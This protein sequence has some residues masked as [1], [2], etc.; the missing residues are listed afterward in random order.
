MMFPIVMLVLN[1]TSVAVL[2]FGAQRSRCGRHADR[3]ADRLPHLPDPDPDVGD[4]GHLLADAAAPRRSVC[5]E[6]IERGAGH[7]LV[8]GA[9]RRTRSSSCRT[10]SVVELADAEFTYPG[11]ESPVLRDITFTARAGP[12]DRDHRLD[13]CRQDHPGLADPA[14]VRRD[15]RSGPGRRGRRPRARSRAALEPDRPGAAEAVPVLRHGGV[16]NLRYGNPDATDEELW[17][18]LRI[19]QAEDFVRAMPGSWTPRS[20][21]A[22]PTSPA[23][24]GNGCPS[25]G[26]W[27]SGRRSTCSTTRSPPWTWP[28]MPGCEPRCE[29]RPPAPRDH[30]RRSGWRPSP[31]PTRSWCWR[32]AQ[33][34]GSGTH[35]E[36]LDTCPTYAEIV[37]SQL[38]AE[39]A[40][41]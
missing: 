3:L 36:L 26:R 5:A 24:S 1:V 27:S 13:R 33:I 35:D 4:D 16:S 11:A 10:A 23:G 15:R 37:D 2:W 40:A 12:D 32:T 18:A 21:R 17:Q 39:E 34:V 38:S 31:T 28:P 7:R 30:R 25:P 6:R 8:G 20:P 41:A 29:P 22:A 19:A 9:G 14:A